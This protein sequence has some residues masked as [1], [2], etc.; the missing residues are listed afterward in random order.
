MD[1]PRL[2]RRDET[3]DLAQ[4]LSDVFG[5]QGRYPRDQFLT[6]L[7]RPVH[8]RGALIIAEDG[9]PVSHILTVID[10]VLIHGCSV[11]VASIGGVCTHPDY[12]GRGYAGRI[13][14]ESLRSTTAQGARLL[15]V[16]GNR[17]LYERN[18]CV[19]AGRTLQAAVRRESAAAAATDDGL[20]A[21]CLP[22][23]DWPTLSPLYSAEPV[24]FV[25]AADFLATCC[26][27]GDIPAPETWLISS[28]GAPVAYLSLA[29]AWGDREPGRR[30]AFE[31]AGSRAAILD[32]LPAIF[33]ET[34]IS[35]IGF[36]VLAADR[37][38]F[39]LLAGR[40]I[41][42]TP[43]SLPGTHRVLDLPGLMRDLRPYLAARDPAYSNATRLPGSRS[44]QA[45][46][47]ER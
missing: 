45:R 32:A 38:L 26:A 13:L 18:H 16:S 2:A 4:L 5:F 35:E 46:A 3:E 25:R 42:L 7:G 29:R 36:G 43:G 47:R 39:Y 27:W 41:P 31:Y 15:I 24:R 34:D 23:N 30:V 40:G 10:R 37:E 9:R 14:E 17:R 1:G 33:H 19:P 8:R 44:P 21:R 20:S 28:R 11:K 22:P 6:A 12:R